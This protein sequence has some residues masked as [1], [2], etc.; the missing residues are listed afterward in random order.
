MALFSK[1]KKS[2]PKVEKKE[3]VK[4]EIVE[5]QQIFKPAVYKKSKAAGLAHVVLIRPIITEKASQSEKNNKYL[6]EVS[7]NKTEIKKAI[8]ELYGVRPIKVNIQKMS[9][10]KVRYGRSQGRTKNW[11]RA[12]VTLK[13]GEKIE[14][15][16][17][18]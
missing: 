3:E 14:L 12:V 4:P 10:K 13:T 8:R 9:G 18:A 17:K 7:S 15:A 2:Q 16:K 5:K 6:F 11:T 1:L